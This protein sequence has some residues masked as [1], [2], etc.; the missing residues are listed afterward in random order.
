[1]NSNTTVSG[2]NSSNELYFKYLKYKL[3]YKALVELKSGGK[4]DSL[5]PNKQKKTILEDTKAIYKKLLSDAKLKYIEL[6]NNKDLFKIDL[7][8]KTYAFPLDKGIVT[9]LVAIFDDKDGIVTIKEI[10]ACQDWFVYYL[11]K[12]EARPPQY[13]DEKTCQCNKIDGR[14]HIKL[15]LID[16]P[17][18]LCLEGKCSRKLTCD[19][20]YLLLPDIEPLVEPLVS[21]LVEPLVPSN[22]DPLYKQALLV[23]VKEVKEVKK[24][25]VIVKEPPKK[26]KQSSDENYKYE[27]LRKSST[28]DN[29]KLQCRSWL[30]SHS[31]KYGNKCIFFCGEEKQTYC[32][33]TIDKVNKLLE[34]KLLPIE[35]IAT[36]MLEQLQNEYGKMIVEII[37]YNTEKNNDLA[38]GFTYKTPAMINAFNALMDGSININNNMV[39]IINLWTIIYYK[40]QKQRKYKKLN[41]EIKVIEEIKPETVS[42]NSYLDKA[43][44]A[45]EKKKLAKKNKSNSSEVVLP[46][47]TLPEVTLPEVTLPEV[48]LPEVTLPEIDYI[49]EEP[50]IEE[51]EEPF[52]LVEHDKYVYFKFSLNSKIAIMG[53]SPDSINS[54]I[55]EFNR[56]TMKCFIYEG[57]YNK[58]KYML[59]EGDYPDNCRK[60]ANIPLQSICT[61]GNC[62]M[63]GL[64]E[65]HI[66]SL[67]KYTNNYTGEE[68]MLIDFEIKQYADKSR[69]IEKLR[70][71]YINMMKNKYMP[72]YCKISSYK[73]DDKSADK[74]I[75]KIELDKLTKTREE[76]IDKINELYKQI[77]KLQNIKK[78]DLCDKYGYMPLIKPLPLVKVMEEKIYVS[79]KEEQPVLPA[80]YTMGKKN[81]PLK[82]KE[83]NKK[84]IGKP[85]GK[86]V[87]KPVESPAELAKKKQLEYKKEQDN[88]LYIKR[89]QQIELIESKLKEKQLKKEKKY[90]EDMMKM[91]KE[92]DEMSE[93]I[94]YTTN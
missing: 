56:R 50:K 23:P 91:N 1:M 42:L 72:L 22:M 29:K 77:L 18:I 46:E 49:I 16:A 79:I 27:M 36:K 87:E 21:P 4:G 57:L 24:N 84:P 94:D 54:I 33:K 78:E 68:A 60:E 11:K 25:V 28:K 3:K 75:M 2:I 90:Q 67:D 34:G 12:S 53:E 63:R 88:I 45:F 14:K 39:G 47:V 30:S 10:N 82:T 62:C 8:D 76:L 80:V 6:K 26:K 44:E 35:E 73:S 55:C 20:S 93:D 52:T 9:Y 66:L 74:N 31:C 48:T 7:M 19:K 51:K 65:G 41:K 64:H 15:L 71:E 70:Q 85:A 43:F 59:I 92:L 32:D 13:P 37:W 5:F 38:I 83:V 61:G 17:C 58:D 89:Q 86:L 81:V 40:S 69:Q